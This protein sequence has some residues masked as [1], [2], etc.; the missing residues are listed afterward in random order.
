MLQCTILNCRNCI[1]TSE[2]TD[3]M[4]DLVEKAEM[5]VLMIGGNKVAVGKDVQASIVTALRVLAI[6]VKGN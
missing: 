2:E 3:E 6:D 1:V 5:V 4:A